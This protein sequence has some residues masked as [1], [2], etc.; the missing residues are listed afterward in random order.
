M[1][2]VSLTE[3]Q[4]AEFIAHMDRCGGGATITAHEERTSY[5]DRKEWVCQWY[6]MTPIGS[7][8]ASGRTFAEMVWATLETMKKEPRA[9]PT[10]EHVTLHPEE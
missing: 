7:Y 10:L 2:D 9:I 4:L 3:A 1:S 6:P 8:F 5:V